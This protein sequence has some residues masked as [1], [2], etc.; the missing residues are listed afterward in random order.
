M[1]P[2]PSPSAPETHD[3]NPPAHLEL[4]RLQARK[5]SEYDMMK[6]QIVSLREK[7]AAQTKGR[8]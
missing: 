7:L 3:A 2:L 1:K 6:T 4:L 8:S 5:E